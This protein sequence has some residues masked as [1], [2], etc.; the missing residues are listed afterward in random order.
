MPQNKNVNYVADVGLYT[1]DQTRGVSAN[2]QT[3]IPVGKNVPFSSIINSLVLDGVKSGRLAGRSI[4]AA[5]VVSYSPA[6]YAADGY[7]P[8]TFSKATYVPVSSKTAQFG[9]SR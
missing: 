2:Y 6:F 1:D 3:R 5:S 9:G 4:A 7:S 8:F